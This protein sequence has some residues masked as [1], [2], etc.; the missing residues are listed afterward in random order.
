MVVDFVLYSVE[1]IFY[2][3]EQKYLDK[4]KKKEKEMKRLFF[5]TVAKSQ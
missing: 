3:E 2:N 1:K 5:T 4:L